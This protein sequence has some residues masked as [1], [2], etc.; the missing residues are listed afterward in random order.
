MNEIC[1]LAQGITELRYLAFSL[2]GL[3]GFLGLAAAYI[4][5]GPIKQIVHSLLA[6]IYSIFGLLGASVIGF[7]LFAN[8]FLC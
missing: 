8:K 6:L 7:L 2:S 1:Q 5:V 4:Y 3:I